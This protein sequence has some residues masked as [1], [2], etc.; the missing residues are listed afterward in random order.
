MSI[1]WFIVFT[2]GVI[3]LQSYIY[4]TYALKR[5]S[6]RRDFNRSHV[7]VNQEVELIDEFVNDQWL[8]IPW[9]RVETK[10]S[11]HLL[12][13]DQSEV[14]EDDQ[15]HQ[16]LF[17]LIP[18][19]R[20][21]RR[22]QMIAK[23]RGVYHL[24]SVAITLGD[25]FGFSEQYRSIETDAKLIVYPQLLK[26][27]QL[28]LD[29]QY[30]LGEQSVKRWIIEDPFLKIGTRELAPSDSAAKINWKKTAQTDTM[31][32]HQHDHTRDQD[33]VLLLNGDQT[34]DIWLPIEND[35]IFESSIT[36][37]A[38]VMYHLN[39]QGAP[40]RFGT[41]IVLNS[42]RIKQNRPLIFKE[43][44][45]GTKHFKQSLET[46]SQLIPERSHNFHYLLDQLLASKQ[47]RMDIVIFSPLQSITIN[48][49][50]RRLEQQ[51]HTVTLLRINH[52]KEGS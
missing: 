43:K 16:T 44:G 51:G 15:F 52:A 48:E 7:Y 49:K 30:F 4:N 9:V 12:R 47:E 33:L 21:K 29:V 40:Y 45:S 11:R 13:I 41:N 25:M 2:I 27:N 50:I 20:I 3:Y 46:L 19:Q 18:Y 39:Q 42:D 37:V 26:K 34:E 23:K 5:L 17:S 35:A 22:H 32:V 1:A 24:Q 14:P 10:L 36:Q 8:P 6:Y 38:S 31:H 28:P